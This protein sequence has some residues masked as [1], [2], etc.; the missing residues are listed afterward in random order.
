[1]RAKKLSFGIVAVLCSFVCFD[2]HAFGRK[3]AKIDVTLKAETQLKKAVTW[4]IRSTADTPILRL[5][6]GEQRIVT[7]RTTLDSASINHSDFTVSGDLVISNSG[8]KKSSIENISVTVSPAIPAQVTCP[9]TALPR[10]LGPGEA[11]QCHYFAQVPDAWNRRVTAAINGSKAV[12]V[13]A[14]ETTADFGQAL[15]HVVDS[16]VSI[17]DTLSGKV[18]NVCYGKD[19]LPRTV[20]LSRPVGPYTECEQ[21]VV[22]NTATFVTSDQ[23]KTGSDSWNIVGM[24]ECKFKPY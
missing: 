24:V 21:F 12:A 20:T 10:Q 17:S 3:S 19:V 7:Y 9:S 2:A 8:K 5:E 1:M 23:T 18:G 4:S 16:C 13:A 6:P 14:A 22:T 15:V 11:V